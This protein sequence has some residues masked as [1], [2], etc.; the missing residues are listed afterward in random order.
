VALSH[1]LVPIRYC[2]LFLATGFGSEGRGRSERKRS[3]ARRYSVEAALDVDGEGIPVVLETF[4]GVDKERK[5]TA[6][7]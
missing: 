3:P 5:R 6:T 2:L 4:G 7:L 1:W